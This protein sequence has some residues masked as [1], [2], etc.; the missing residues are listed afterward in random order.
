M[1]MIMRVKFANG[2]GDHWALWCKS[3][4]VLKLM[5]KNMMWTKKLKIQDKTKWS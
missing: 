5:L 2:L 3:A 1:I 4:N